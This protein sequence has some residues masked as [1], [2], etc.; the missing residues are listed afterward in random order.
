MSTNKRRRVG[1][2]RPSP[3]DRRPDESVDEFDN[4]WRWVTTP[5]GKRQAVFVHTWE[6]E[7]DDV[8]DRPPL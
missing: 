8:A 3:S 4:V 7:S 5:D 6:D 2:K 1:H